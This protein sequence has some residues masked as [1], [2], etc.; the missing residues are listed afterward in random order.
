MSKRLTILLLALLTALACRQHEAPKQPAKLSFDDDG[1]LLIDGERTFIIGTYH[2][3]KSENPYAELAEA[4]FNL[5]R[6]EDK[7]EE[8]DK[9]HANG[10]WTWVN[11]GYID[12]TKDESAKRVERRVQRLKDHPALLVWET[13]DEP[14][15]TWNSAEMRVRPEPLIRTYNLVKQI[16]PAH[17]FYM[18][19]S[20]VNLVSTLQ[21]YNPATDIVACDIYPVI[22]RGIRISYALNPDGLQGDLLN[23]YLSQVGEYADKMRRVAGP[24]R[25]LFMVL[26][27]FAW[28]MLRKENDRD[29]NMILYPTLE[30]SRFMAYNA[31][32]HGANGILYWGTSYTPQPSQFWSDLKA[33]TRELHSIKDVLAARSV[34]L[35]IEK[36]Y[37]ELGH[38]VDAGV[39][40]LAKRIGDAL[41]LITANADRYP[42]KVTFKG[43]SGFSTAHILFEDRNAPISSG[44]LTEY[45]RPFDVHVFKLEP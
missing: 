41:Y 14:A 4:G 13:C 17:L 12:T 34:S 29:P 21:K 40:V 15:F 42:E 2:R 27:G 3:P 32:I 43:L 24:H 5:V 25:P 39:E 23:P 8:L 36:S 1:M 11:I 28:E 30:Q 26:Q 7:R 10:L 20:P 37:H 16:D 35:P 31:I 19:H 45:Y 9:A 38:S 6:V 18:N 22:P 33:V 44:E